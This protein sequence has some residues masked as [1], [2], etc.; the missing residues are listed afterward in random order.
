MAK[1]RVNK[2]KCIGCAACTIIAPEVFELG[3]DGKSKVKVEDVSGE[4][5]EKAKQAKETCPTGAIEIE[6]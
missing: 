2:D 1:V 3:E 5:L 4:L 6:E